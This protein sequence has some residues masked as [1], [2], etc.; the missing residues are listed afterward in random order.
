[1]KAEFRFT[2]KPVESKDRALV[3][4][5]LAQPHVAKWFYGQGLENTFN[6][7][8]EFLQGSSQSHYWLAY[9]KRHP[10]AFLIT[11]SVSKPHDELTCWCSQEGEAITLD[12]LIGD[13]NYLGK[14]LSHVLIKEFLVSQFP[15]VTEVLIDPEATNVKAVHVYQKV[16]FKILGEFI[17][18]HS[19]HPHYMMR[20]EMK[21]LSVNEQS[22]K[23]AAALQNF[24]IELQ[25]LSDSLKE[26]IYEG[27]SRHAIAMIG[28]D[29]KFDTV[30]FKASD[31]NGS[32]AG[33]VVVELFWGALHVKYMYVEDEYRG[34][35]LGSKLIEHALTYGRDNQCPF[36]FV[37]TMSFQALGFYQKMGFELEF[38]RSGY[39]HDASFHYLRKNL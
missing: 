16:G 2:F 14:G 6:H 21:E 31:K 30:T 25:P 26:R 3:H 34:C 19:P 11:S 39:K 22:Q 17:P 20:L 27:F 7:L 24:E 8:D 29:E 37:E 15:N 9:E 35:G 23:V 4:E 1:M 32:F 38:S 12:M 28:H 36:A 33:A 13:T 5:W 10:F 18:S